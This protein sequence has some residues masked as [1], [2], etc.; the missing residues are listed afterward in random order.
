MGNGRYG[1]R[2]VIIAGLLSFSPCA[3]ADGCFFARSDMA[4]PEQRAAILFADGMEDLIIQVQYD[5][6]VDDF[7]WL[8]PLPSKPEV[9]VVEQDLF[10]ELRTYVFERSK[11]KVYTEQKRY[12]GT[13]GG[14]RGLSAVPRGVTV[15]ER[16][17]VGVY[18]VAILSADSVDDLTA[19]CTGH[20]YHVPDGAEAVLQSY[21]D[22]AW[23]FTAMRIHPN[24]KEKDSRVEALRTGQIQAMRFQFPT[25][26]AIYPLRISSI[27]RGATDVLV[28][29]I[30]EDALI[31]PDFMPR[32][33]ANPDEF[34]LH[35]ADLSLSGRTE[36][37]DRFDHCYDA[38]RMT[39]RPVTVD[40]LPATGEALSRWGRSRLYINALQQTFEADE[41]DDDVV[42]LAP[43]ELELEAQRD[44]V[45]TCL[46]N[47]DPAVDVVV[48]RKGSD[49]ARKVKNDTLSDPVLSRMPDALHDVIAAKLTRDPGEGEVYNQDH[50]QKNLELLLLVLDVDGR[51]TLQIAAQHRREQVRRALFNA[52]EQAC[53]RRI[54]SFQPYDGQNRLGV[55]YYRIEA[56]PGIPKVALG[57]ILPEIFQSD[58]VD[59]YVAHMLAALDTESATALLLS[60]ARG[61]LDGS[62]PDG[63][64]SRREMAL[65]ALS[66]M[67][68]PAVIDVYRYLFD[69]QQDTLKSDEVAHCLLGLGTSADPN[70]VRL[71]RQIE[72]YCHRAGM[73][74]EARLARNL[75]VNRFRV[76][77]PLIVEEMS[78]EELEQEMGCR[79]KVVRKLRAGGVEVIQYE[80][81]VGVATVKGDVLVKWKPS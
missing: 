43:E 39:Y 42:F 21:V 73:K 47:E 24:E 19:W 63:L 80:W 30:A 54:P 33:P 15:H 52:L 32:H 23:V 40:E 59:P 72:I 53:F 75:L 60:A 1:I 57:K 74:E 16:R 41:M 13:F 44:Y 11:W 31:H 70:G 7:A 14:S 34:R 48:Q 78:L 46:G 58:E 25:Q 64:V 6:A 12:R 37:S 67:K 38:Q 26:E 55:R 9:S 68:G 77:E 35:R 79:G 10:N 65:G 49:V 28:Y 66:Q 3:M 5:G 71:V 27:N 81:P 20:G 69:H 61:E 36:R 18:D 22:R 45:R 56:L 50:W 51:E 4:E 29:V 2:E 17:K 62:P 76:R 8:V